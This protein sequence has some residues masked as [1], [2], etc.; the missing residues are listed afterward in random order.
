MDNSKVKVA[1]LIRVVSTIHNIDEDKYFVEV[2][3]RDVRGNLARTLLARGL[4]RPGSNV[5]EQLLNRGANFPSRQGA[6]AELLEVLSGGSGPINRITSRVGWHDLSFVLPDVTIGPDAGTL[7]YRHGEPCLDEQHVAGTLNDWRNQL[8]TPCLA[9]SYLTFGVGLGFAGPVLQLIGQDE[10]VSFYLSGQSSTGKTLSELGAVSVIELALRTKLL[11]HDVTPRKLEEAAAAHNDLALV[12]DEIDRSSGSEAELRKHVRELGHKLAGGV[13]RQRSARATQDTSLA[14]LCW[15]LFSLWSGEY[16]LDDC[17]LGK[18]RRRGEI[19]RLIEIPVPKRKS[20]GIFDRMESAEV[21][22]GELAKAAEDAIK[23]NFGHPIREFLQRLV[24]DR[25]SLADRAAVL[26]SEFVREV[27]AK[28][29]PWTQRFATKFAVVYAA[30]QLAAEMK[31]APWPKGH[32]FKCVARLYKRAREVVATPEEALADVLHRL[33]ANA[34]SKG[35]F[36]VLKKGKALPKSAQKKAWGIRRKVLG[37]PPNLAVHS[38][39]FDALVQPRKH[40]AQVRQLLADG[41][42]TLP[43]KEGRFVSQLKVK[44]FGSAKPYFIRVRLDRLPRLV[45]DV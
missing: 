10:G 20:G 31:I 11:T 3:F 23:N 25:Q 1:D 9:S 12:I 5:L 6:G 34:T 45:T 39:T 21:S 2:E 37:T 17:F 24:G 44:G 42:Y 30:A 35:R 43:G 27:G 7:K 26:V 22:S 19:V 29:D 32:A 18:V 40:A 41:G 16:P 15:R 14:N 28:S 38:K 8:R 13:G 36:P 33:A 4:I